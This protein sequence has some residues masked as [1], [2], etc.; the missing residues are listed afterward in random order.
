[1]EITSPLLAIGSSAVFS[2]GVDMAFSGMAVDPAYISIAGAVW[3]NGGWWYY[4]ATNTSKLYA[5]SSL[6]T[7]A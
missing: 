5:E 2:Q 4:D 6:I 1:M 3:R 7:F